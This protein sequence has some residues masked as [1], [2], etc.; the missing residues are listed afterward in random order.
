VIGA[1]LVV[2]NYQGAALL[3]R[4]IPTLLRAVEAHPGP[5]EV[6]VVDDGSRDD[7]LR[8]LREELPAARVVVHERNQGFGAACKTG[9]E[10]AAHPVVVLLNSDVTVEPGFLAPLLGPFERDP[11]VFSVSPLILDREGRPSKVTVNLPRVR[12]GELKWDGVDPEDLLRLSRLDPAV[13]LEIPSLF[14]LGG[15]VAVSRARFLALGGF[16]PLLRPFY[17][18]DVDL[19]LCAWRRGWRVLV[20]PRS[21]VTHE[22]G[23]TIN[24]HFAPFRVKVARRRHRL[25]VGWKHAEGAWRRA[26]WRGLAWR[27]LTR[28]LRLDLRFYAAAWS[29]WGRRAEARAAHAREVAATRARL[30]D[31]V[32]PAIRAAWPPA[33]LQG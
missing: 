9:V 25:L 16:D 11:A 28:W 3:R 32:F 18:E 4:N 23:G 12:R 8:V 6:V 31:E 33:A 1:S 29:A 2:P 30:E 15:A 20:E 10:A 27:V 5:A 21:R 19:G 14:G 26:M 17:H 13:P 22:D 7:S 24:R